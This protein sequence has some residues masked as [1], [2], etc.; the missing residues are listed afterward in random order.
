[1]PICDKPVILALVIDEI[2]IRKHV[3]WDGKKFHGYVYYGVD[4]EDDQNELAKDAFVLMIVCL[5]GAW[6]L[7]VGYFFADGLSG[8]QKSSLVSQCVELIRE[9]GAHVLSLTFD[10]APLNI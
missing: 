1:M 9:T 3:E 7:T 10:G 2:S 4:L 8:L 6:K 5:N